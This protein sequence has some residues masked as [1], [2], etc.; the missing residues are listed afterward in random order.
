MTQI[1]VKESQGQY[2]IEVDVNEAGCIVHTSIT[3]LFMVPWDKVTDV[4]YLADTFS[5][6]CVG[7]FALLIPALAKIAANKEVY[8]GLK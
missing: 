7:E 4:E 6:T 2:S 5:D 8:I 3:E 1:I